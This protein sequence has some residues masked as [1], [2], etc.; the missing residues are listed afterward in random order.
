MT[1]RYVHL[2][3]I[4]EPTLLWSVKPLKKTMKKL[5]L[6][7]TTFALVT[8]SCAQ[9]LDA[10]YKNRMQMAL[11]IHDTASVYESEVKAI[12]AF[13]SITKDYKQAWLPHYW[14]SYIY[15]QIARTRN[16]PDGRTP[17][18]LLEESQKSLDLAKSKMPKDSPNLESDVHALQGFIYYFLSIGD[19]KEKEEEWRGKMKLAYKKAIS[20]NPENPLIY[21]LQGT[22][23]LQDKERIGS[24][25]AGKVLLNE[26][27]R[28]F[29][30][31]NQ[32]RALTTNWNQEWL[33]LYWLKFADRQLAEVAGTP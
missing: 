23:L 28:L 7:F 26:A 18:K 2:A 32:P 9:D 4:N 13:Q 16:A 29:K 31:T 27:N 25:L 1:A 8:M 6:L 20:L 15:T 33:Y 3:D 30:L 21:V 17:L 11:F 14:A 19:K 24:V 5:T 10:K 12:E 22:G